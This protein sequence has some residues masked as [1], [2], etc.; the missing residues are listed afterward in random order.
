[1]NAAEVT[2]GSSSV[3]KLA[4]A[5][6]RRFFIFV[7]M[8]LSWGQIWVG[9]QTVATYGIDIMTY[10]GINNASLALISNVV[11]IAVG[12]GCL[13]AGM[14]GAKIGGKLTV[15]IG[16][17]IDF[18]VG[19]LFFFLTPDNVG[20]LVILRILEGFGGG[21]IN[22]YTVNMIGAWFPRKERGFALGLQMGLYGVVVA[23]TVV[24]CNAFDSMGL[25]WSQSIGAFLM[26]A[27]AL[28]LVLGVFGLKDI[29]KEYGVSVIDEVLEGYEDTEIEDSTAVTDID[30]KPASYIEAFKSPALWI[31][32]GGISLLTANQYLLQFVY[33]MIL[34]E[35][36]YSTEDISFFLATAF[37][38]TIIAAPLG[39]LLSDRV[40]KG[41]RWQVMFICFFSTT[42][43]VL[44][45]VF[46]GVSHVGIGVL[47]IVGFL[48]F[49]LSDMAVGVMYAIPPEIFDSSFFGKA[50]GIVLL[51]CNIIGLLTVVIGGALADTTGSYLIPCLLCV[52]VSVVGIVC[53]VALHKKYNG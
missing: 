51:S 17:G 23:T 48:T 34:P 49:A 22:G 35:W 7:I 2:Q 1:M 37:L 8:V 5:P 24:F 44:L 19:V 21:L 9:M 14:I 50:N 20:F 11:T 40:F 29:E 18:V 32:A 52:P 42:I 26:L 33:P 13:V 53:A 12:V 46:S 47:L 45:F 4:K 30:H 6:M 41:K 28:C 10:L 38:G 25:T 31:V 39:G 27:T 3:R 15:F 16:L 43:A 36:N